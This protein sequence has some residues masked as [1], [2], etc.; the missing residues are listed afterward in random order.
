MRQIRR[1]AYGEDIGQHS[2][3]TKQELEGEI[4][5]LQLTNVS[6]LLDLGCGP[7]GALAFIVGLTGCT[8][9]GIDVSA[10]A[11]AAARRCC[12]SLGLEAKLRF[13]QADL[14]QPLPFPAASF[15]A[16]VALD[17]ILHLQDRT[18]L[19][20]E[21][22]RILIPGSRFLFT[23]AAVVTGLVSADEFRVRASRGY[24]QFVSPGFNEHALQEAGLDGLGVIDRTSS[25][26][27]TAKGRLHARFAHESELKDMEGDTNFEKEQQYL[28]SVV[29][30]SQRGALSRM[31]YL[32]QAEAA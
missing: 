30:L 8:G 22:R 13:Q 26:L 19:F 6:R 18:A 1:E 31:S 2:W 7:G 4:A 16:V 9:T 29:E 3:V 25:L 10:P 14:N 11:I 12:F 17:V 20:R 5:Q 21:I 24:A 28:A 15:E 23:D 27:A 32:A